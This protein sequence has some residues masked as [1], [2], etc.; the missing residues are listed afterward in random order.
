[1]PHRLGFQRLCTNKEPRIHIVLGLSPWFD[2]NEDLDMWSKGKCFGMPLT[3][4][5]NQK[6]FLKNEF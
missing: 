2:Y 6:L 5:I 3:K 4:I 1:V